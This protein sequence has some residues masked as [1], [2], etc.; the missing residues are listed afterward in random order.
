MKPAVYC[1]AGWALLCSPAWAQEAGTSSTAAKPKDHQQLLDDLHLRLDKL[2]FRTDPITDRVALLR[3]TAL[4]ATIARTKA[5]I[6]HKNELGGDFYLER[7]V[8]TLDG[9]AI[10][11]KQDA[12]GSLNDLAEIELFN[13]RISPGTH[14]LEVTYICR[15][16]TMGV[17]SYASAYRFKIASKYAFK[18]RD[19][20]LTQ[21]EIVAFKKPD[22]TLDIT[23]R[24]SIR[25]DYQMLSGLPLSK[26]P[27]AAPKP[28]KTETKATP[29]AGK[30]S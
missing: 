11:N 17:F 8:Y 9:A 24:L 13:G 5:K 22:I 16:G 3:D 30:G 23:R 15:A 27:E 6:V 14:Q 12:S 1:F 2:A 28:E 20:R 10:F 25:Y 7:A 26:E 4:G 29:S 19:G 18:V 21:L